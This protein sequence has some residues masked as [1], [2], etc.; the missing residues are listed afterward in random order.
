M[1]DEM[2][3]E[4]VPDGE[5]PDDERVKSRARALEEENAKPD[6]PGNRFTGASNGVI[7]KGPTVTVGE[8]MWW[9]PA[10]ARP[11]APMTIRNIPIASEKNCAMP[12]GSRTAARSSETTDSCTSWMCSCSRAMFN[13]L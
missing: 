7:V 9:S 8:S 11:I 5:E 12:N 2:I 4:R 6:G 10:R 13:T 3:D 1:G